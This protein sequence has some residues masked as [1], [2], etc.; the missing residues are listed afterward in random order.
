[1]NA[2]TILITDS[3]DEP[4]TAFK[5][6]CP[7]GYQVLTILQFIIWQR[8]EEIKVKRMKAW[9]ETDF[10]NLEFYNQSGKKEYGI[11]PK[12][13]YEKWKEYVHY[14]EAK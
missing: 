1:M 8:E 10:K 11:L 3:D 5:H 9:N 12:G 13:W 14:T 7:E 4:S 2:D 6:R